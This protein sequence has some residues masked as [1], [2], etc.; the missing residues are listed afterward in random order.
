M[1]R[2]A[3]GFTLLELLVAVAI[4]AVVSALAFEGLSQALKA[5][6]RLDHERR[7]W[8][9]LAITFSELKQDLAQARP[10]PVRNAAGMMVPAFIGLPA[11]ETAD[12]GSVLQFTRGGA[13]PVRHGPASTLERVGYEVRGHGLVR[14]IWPVLDRAPNTRP[15]VSPILNGVERF[16]VRFY[17]TNGQWSRVWPLPGGQLTD[18]PRGVRVTLHLKDHGTFKRWFVVGR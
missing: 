11:G 17:E 13:F 5:R 4:F 15:L 12:H 9:G 18:L 3:R 1:T 6:R 2:R 16:R 10:R 7:F 8:Q 14:L